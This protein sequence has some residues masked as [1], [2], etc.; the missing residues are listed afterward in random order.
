M[1]TYRV[2]WDIDIDG[3]TPL[4]AARMAQTIMRDADSTA[5]VFTVTD[6]NGHT[7]TLDLADAA[8][9]VF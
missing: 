1:P 6:E 4:E 7:T 2:T 5:T 9:P 8:A 3:T